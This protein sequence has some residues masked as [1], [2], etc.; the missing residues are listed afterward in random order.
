MIKLSYNQ[1]HCE[2]GGIS[3]KG[4]DW[5]WSSQEANGDMEATE[6]ITESVHAAVLEEWSDL[7]QDQDVSDLP[8]E[9]DV[10]WDGEIVEN[11]T[12]VRLMF[13]FNS[14]ALEDPE[15]TIAEIQEYF[16]SPLTLKEPLKAGE[17]TATVGTKTLTIT[18]SE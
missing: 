6:D 13:D 10:E 3:G 17:N 18:I 16:K 5:W 11:V 12:D 1:F 9:A 8:L 7:L 14:P 4:I 2:S 15:Q